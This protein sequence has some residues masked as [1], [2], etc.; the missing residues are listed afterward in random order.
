MPRLC[1]IPL[2][3]KLNFGSKSPAIDQLATWVCLNR[4]LH[5]MGDILQL[6]YAQASR[7]TGRG[8]S[9]HKNRTA[10]ESKS[11]VKQDCAPA[12]VRGTREY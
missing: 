12:M 4:H 6:S 10:W 1:C 3:Q 2:G 8:L 5:I 11:Y 9:A 7:R